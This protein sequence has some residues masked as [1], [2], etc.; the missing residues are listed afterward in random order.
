MN[1][2]TIRTIWHR[3]GLPGD[4][5][6]K[7]KQDSRCP[8]A[9]RHN[10]ADRKPSFALLNN[11][12]NFSCQG[13]GASGG[14]LDFIGEVQGTDRKTAFAWVRSH[15]A[16]ADFKAP[17]RSTSSS[18]DLPVVDVTVPP[19]LIPWP[20]PLLDPTLELRSKAAASRGLSCDVFERA[21]G[22][23]FVRYGMLDK[24]EVWILC[25]EP[26]GPDGLSRIYEARPIAGGL[27]PALGRLSERKTHTKC[28]T[29]GKGWPVGA[30]LAAKF[31]GATILLV[32]GSA[33]FMAAFQICMDAAVVPVAILGSS[34]IHSA[35]LH[36]FHGRRVVVA[37][38]ADPNGKG[39]DTAR[40]WTEQLRGI[41]CTVTGLKFPPG[42][43][44]NDL[45][46]EGRTDD[47]LEVLV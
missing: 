9:D 27:L 2:P 34:R 39:R 21:E 35:A 10:H 30:G 20:F 25:S 47:I 16:V 36:Y 1:L 13:C 33:D 6:A 31:R 43:D 15:F 45:V 19:A 14:V 46:R 38:H 3:L 42:S 22:V 12:M 29:G 26:E 23:G 24:D 41:S 4:P 17:M 37:I 28:A 8:F 11:G 7:D 18:S 5:P 40:Q 32:E 44:L